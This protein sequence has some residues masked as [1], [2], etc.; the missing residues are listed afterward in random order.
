MKTQ[1]FMHCPLGIIYNFSAV[2][3]FCYK[4]F[5]FP[6]SPHHYVAG[7]WIQPVLG[8]YCVTAMTDCRLLWTGTSPFVLF[9]SEYVVSFSIRHVLCLRLVPS[10]YYFLVWSKRKGIG[11]VTSIIIEWWQVIQV[12][13]KSEPQPK[14]LEL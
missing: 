14:G 6:P 4:L 12:A 1:T 5:L 7:L 13:A 11:Y 2:V 8:T 10:Y 3:W 9:F